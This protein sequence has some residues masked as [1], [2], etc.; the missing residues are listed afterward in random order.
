[1]RYTPAAALRINT[2]A[3]YLGWLR[4]SK[5]AP[6]GHDRCQDRQHPPPHGH[7]V[8]FRAELSDEFAQI[9]DSNASKDRDRRAAHEAD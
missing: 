1:M 5:A 4:A 6:A 8:F 7:A 3:E 2:I 9:E